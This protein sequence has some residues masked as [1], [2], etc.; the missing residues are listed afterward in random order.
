[1]PAP[2]DA[3]WPPTFP[4][5]A[6]GWG[7][8]PPRRRTRRW[9]ALS[10]VALVLALAAAGVAVTLLRRD[11]GG[12]P[13]A[14]TSPTTTTTTMPPAT[15]AGDVGPVGLITEEPTCVRW[16]AISPK[17][18]I[19]PPIN[20]AG[21]SPVTVP[22]NA[23]TPQ[24]QSAMQTMANNIRAEA[25]QTAVLAN[26]TPHRVM[27]ELYEQFVAYGRAFADTAAGNYVPEDSGLLYSKNHLLDTLVSVCVAIRAGAPAARSALV[28]AAPGAP[29][30][31]APPQDPA[32]PQRFVTASDVPACVGL[33]SLTRNYASN[34]TVTAWIDSDKTIPASQWDPKQKALNDAVA[35][36]MLTLADDVE[37]TTGQGNNP[38]MA[39]FGTL[40][41]QY[42]RVFAKALPLYVPSDFQ[43][44]GVASNMLFM[45]AQACQTVGA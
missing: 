34:P 15:S 17:W 19:D 37:H 44:D 24:Q 23:W 20:I 30:R 27:R 7:P 5:P 29:S 12:G 10:G 4:P 36:I 13:I 32:D 41:V 14:A 2:Y 35:P 43:L 18:P 25:R 31:V 39:D 1:M 6:P 3:A 21:V 26:T 28:T 33:E 42:Q 8:P 40:F 16:L 38:V 9:W 22:R 45:M 11:S